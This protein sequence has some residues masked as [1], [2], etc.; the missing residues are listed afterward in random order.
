MESDQL[1]IILQKTTWSRK[2]TVLI[3]TPLLDYW[4]PKDV[5]E[6]GKINMF[7]C[8]TALSK[9]FHLFQAIP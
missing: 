6:F 7:L 9:V 4:F 2:D 1:S 8:L 3:Q 5:A